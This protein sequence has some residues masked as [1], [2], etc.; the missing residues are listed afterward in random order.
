M[1][2]AMTWRVCRVSAIQ[3]QHLRLFLQTNDQSSSNSNSGIMPVSGLIS[4][5]FKPGS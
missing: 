1:T 3:I 4:V 2:Y 5:M